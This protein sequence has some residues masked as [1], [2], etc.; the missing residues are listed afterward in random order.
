VN[1]FHEPEAPEALRKK[2]EEVRARERELLEEQQRRFMEDTADHAL[3]R[4]LTTG[5]IKQTLFRL[6]QKRLFRNKGV[7]TLVRIYSG[8]GK[9][10]VLFNV[11]NHEPSKKPWRVMQARMVAIR[12]GEDPEI[13]YAFGAARPFALRQ[14]RDEVAFDEV[15]NVAVVVDK[16]AF[17]TENGPTQLLLELYNQDGW[18]Q[19]YVVLDVQ[20]TRF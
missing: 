6:R 16:R 13:P 10:A 18:R 4:I 5:D 9:A 17:L 11:T 12:P 2:L 8:K 15:G 1:V 19:A 3:A 14:D 20:L 7:E